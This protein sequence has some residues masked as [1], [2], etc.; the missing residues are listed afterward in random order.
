LKE[1][2]KHPV[3]DLVSGVA[4]KAGLP[5]YVVGGWVRDLLLQ[6]PSKDVDIVVE[7]SG[8]ELATLVANKIG[9]QGN[10]KVYKNFGTAMLRLND[11]E[12]EF[13]GA[14][15]ESYR[16]D[17]RKPIVEDGSL[18]EDLSRRDFTINA[19]AIGLSGENHGILI[20]PFNGQEDLERKLI[21]TPLQP[22]ITFSDDP[23]RMMRALRFA[24][25]L[26]F[27][28]EY[29]SLDAIKDNAH[30]LSIVSMERIMDEFNKIVLSPTPG[31]ALLKVY[32][33]QMLPHFFYELQLLAGVEVVNQKA[34]KDVLLHTF[35]VLDNL[36]PNSD[37]LWL[38]WAVLLHDIAKPATKRFD[39]ETGWTFH[40]HEFVGSKMVPRI[41]ARLKLP[42]D[43]KMKYVQK[44]VLLH[45]RPIVLSQ[46][47]VTDSAVRRL[48][49]EAGD[50]IDDLMLLCEA[51][52]TSGNQRKV[53]QFMENFRLVRKKLVEIEEKDRLRNWQPPVS[54]NE[55][56]EYFGIRPSREVGVIKTAIREAILDGEIPNERDAAWKFMIEQGE[57]IGLT[58]AGKSK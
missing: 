26:K 40:G 10:L 12:I 55:I 11:Y 31:R 6:R 16:L 43:A 15:K 50:D 46:S 13:V 44:L 4:V 27:D 53:I 51:D 58:P 57:K 33:A 30:R 54:G 24:A 42:L 38:R 9:K 56:M 23:L 5:A 41:F 20:D 47:I 21:K 19:M 36:A 45:L 39:E 25:Q 34:H 14:R 17:S 49:F 37:N 2:L 28:I 22:G 48:L 8:I 1:Y 7:G 18:H 32:E 3:L 29:E 52:I 35:K